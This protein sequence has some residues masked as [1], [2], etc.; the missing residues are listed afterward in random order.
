MSTASSEQ[1]LR[2]RWAIVI[3]ERAGLS[4]HKSFA[5]L[6]KRGQAAL[7]NKC[8]LYSGVSKFDPFQVSQP[9]MHS[10]CASKKAARMDR[11]SRLFAHSI[12]SPDSWV[13]DIEVE[14]DESLR[15]CPRIFP[16]R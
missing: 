3:A 16:F 1:S 6:S 13:A 12:L 15:S 9:F 4:L 8:L 5:R 11:K 10:A 14:I 2:R 7:T